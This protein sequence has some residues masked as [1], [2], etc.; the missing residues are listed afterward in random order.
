MVI[1]GLICRL[2]LVSRA[3][4]GVVGAELRA[5]VAVA[6][7][8][9]EAVVAVGNGGVSGSLSE[10]VRVETLVLSVLVN[11]LVEKAI[12]ETSEARML[13]GCWLLLSALCCC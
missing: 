11:V 1:A 8:A 5:V 4:R 3:D 2:R 10:T 13:L 9:G 6:G 7:A 12:A